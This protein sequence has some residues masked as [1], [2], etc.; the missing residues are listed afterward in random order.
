MYLVLRFGF[1]C[2][3][4]VLNIQAK[5][6]WVETHLWVVNI[7]FYGLIVY[8]CLIYIR[9]W[10]LLF[11]ETKYNASFKLSF[12]FEKMRFVKRN[13]G[14]LLCSSLKYSCVLINFSNKIIKIINLSFQFTEILYIL[15]ERS[16]FFSEK[17]SCFLIFCL[18]NLWTPIFQLTKLLLHLIFQLLLF[19]LFICFLVNSPNRC[20]NLMAAV[21]KGFGH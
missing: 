2:S 20:A 14:Y 1:S 8:E 21:V 4:T 3:I 18:R 12:S 19:S 15:F 17:L 16:I 7:E 6:Y 9:H 5:T 11:D 10:K 13:H